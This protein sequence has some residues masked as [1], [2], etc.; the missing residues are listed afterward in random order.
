MPSR[1]VAEMKRKEREKGE[2][3]ARQAADA[4]AKELGYASHEDMISKLKARK[5]APA[6]RAAASTAPAARASAEPAPREAR[7]TDRRMQRVEEQRR[8]ANRARA[9]AERKQREMQRSMDAKEAEHALRLAAVRAG[10]KDPEYA[11]HVLQKKLERT[12]AKEL[13]SFDEDAFFST[14]L[15]K[16]HPYLYAEVLEPAH[17]SPNPK[18]GHTPKSPTPPA[19]AS[20][21]KDARTL[22]STEFNTL[23]RSKGLTPPSMGSI[24]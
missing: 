6:P 20:N 19:P 12:P 15:R 23:L 18:A 7:S 5:N 13:E 9:S 3:R 11:L 1:A 10:I 22:S 17:T 8:A 2:R 24:S 4:S 14:E 21:G 16:S